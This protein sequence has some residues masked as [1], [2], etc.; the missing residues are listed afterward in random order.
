MIRTKKDLKDYLNADLKSHNLDGWNIVK[1]IRYPIMDFQWRLRNTEYIVNNSRGKLSKIRKGI[2]LYRL[3]RSGIK[4]GFTI[5]PNVFGPGLC[6][7]HW[8]TLVVNPKARIGANCRIHPGTTIGATDEGVPQIGDDA[9]IGPGARL[10]GPIVLGDRVVIAANAVVNK[11][12]GS[13]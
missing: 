13:D 10:F 5:P 2:A 9:Y 7:V 3:R 1:S 8:G 4:L 11:S 12:Y 6:I